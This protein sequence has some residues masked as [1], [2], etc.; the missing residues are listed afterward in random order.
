MITQRKLLH[1]SGF[2]LIELL[3]VVLI[4]GILSA[5]ALPQYTKAVE[6]ARMSEALTV[7]DSIR[8]GIDIYMLQNGYQTANFVGNWV[9]GAPKVELDI[10]MEKN[11]DCPSGSDVCHSKYF[12]YDALCDDSLCQIRATPNSKDFPDYQLYYLIFSENG[13]WEKECWVYSDDGVSICNALQAQG[14]TLDDER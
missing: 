3:V 12:D 5:I 2:T 1:R 14:W 8:K 10:D 6:K 7:M 11:L 13:F 4:I 9:P